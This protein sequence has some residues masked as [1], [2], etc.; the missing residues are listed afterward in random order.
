MKESLQELKETKPLYGV[1]GE[2]QI[3]DLQDLPT[4][5]KIAKKTNGRVWEML[6]EDDNVTFLYPIE[7]K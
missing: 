7:Q 6:R 5:Q 4:A 3:L 1:I 2:Q